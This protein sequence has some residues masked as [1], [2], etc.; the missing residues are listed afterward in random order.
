MA[1]GGTTYFGGSAE[2]QFPLFGLPKELGLKGALFAD[3]GTL[4]GFTDKTDF[5]SLVGY[6]YCPAGGARLPITQ[7]SCLRV[8]DEHMIRTRRRQ[9]ALGFAAGTDP[10]RLRLP[11]HK[12]KYDQTQFFNFTGGAT[13]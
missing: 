10:V 3:A 1:L 4:Y 7:P 9:L 11:G 8:W 13:F 5:S 12:G 6:T 2:M